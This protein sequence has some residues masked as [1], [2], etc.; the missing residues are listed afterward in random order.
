MHQNILSLGA[1]TADHKMPCCKIPG[2]DGCNPRTK[3]W[4][5]TQQELCW[6]NKLWDILTI[7]QCWF[8]YKR[9][10]EVCYRLWRRTRL[11]GGGWER[12]FP[13]LGEGDSIPSVLSRKFLSW[14]I[15]KNV[16]S[17]LLKF[18]IMCPYVCVC[19]HFYVRLE[20][21]NNNTSKDSAELYFEVRMLTFL[22][23]KNITYE[24]F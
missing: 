18:E 11:Q 23:Q 20:K 22:E 1:G 24:E 15:N 5:E 16:I 9:W 6:G 17:L 10:P 8:Q 19:L 14:N 3:K 4:M 7:D 21:G 2:Q 12:L 13:G